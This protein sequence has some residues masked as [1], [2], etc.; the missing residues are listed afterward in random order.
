[1]YLNVY[2]YILMSGDLFLAYVYFF[3]LPF[4]FMNKTVF[5]VKQ[6]LKV[7]LKTLQQGFRLIFKT[8]ACIDLQLCTY[9]DV[10]LYE[11]QHLS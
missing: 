1:M 4:S 3:F 5:D 10:D 2:M 9:Q 8:V 6:F 7:I 11:F